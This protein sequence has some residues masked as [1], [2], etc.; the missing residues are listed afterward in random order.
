MIAQ[1]EWLKTIELR[2]EIILGEHVVMPDHMHMVLNIAVEEPQAQWTDEERERRA[3]AVAGKHLTK[4]K[5]VST[6]IRGFKGAVT[7]QVLEMAESI[8]RDASQASSSVKGACDAPQLGRDASQA[9]S[10]SE[11]G[12]CDAPQLGRNVSIASLSA[13][14]ISEDGACDAPQRASPKEINLSRQLAGEKTIWI[15]NYYDHIIRSDRAYKNIEQYIR[16][17]PINWK[18]DR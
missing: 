4:A 9:S 16:D 17:N 10:F 12:A 7:K 18:K 3:G 5:S 2:E 11:E 1:N 13:Q 6:I 8:R 14:G 15:R